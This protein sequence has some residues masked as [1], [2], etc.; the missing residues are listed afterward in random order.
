MRNYKYTAETLTQALYN[1]MS[2]DYDQRRYYST[3]E[4][5]CFR[6]I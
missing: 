1:L 6:K 2:G 4:I 5:C 3:L